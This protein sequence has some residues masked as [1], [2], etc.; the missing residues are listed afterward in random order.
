MVGATNYIPGLD[1]ESDPDLC[2]SEATS[3]VDMA[4]PSDNTASTYTHVLHSC[5]IP[6]ESNEMSNKPT[7][8]RD[9]IRKPGAACRP[10]L[11]RRRRITVL[12]ELQAVIHGDG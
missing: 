5:S 9:E 7:I 6:L 3:A 10:R 4:C 11:C 8:S 2:I 12:A 1:L